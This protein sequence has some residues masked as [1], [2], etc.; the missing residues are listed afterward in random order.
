MHDFF[1]LFKSLSYALP[2]PSYI[3]PDAV[4]LVLIVAHVVTSCSSYHYT[5]FYFF[6]KLVSGFWRGC[7]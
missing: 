7:C 5:T 6:F 4:T 2:S 3:V 1:V